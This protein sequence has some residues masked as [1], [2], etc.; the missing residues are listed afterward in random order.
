M[1]GVTMQA[2]NVV[3]NEKQMSYNIHWKECMDK[4]HIFFMYIFVMDVNSMVGGQGWMWMNVDE[5]HPPWLLNIIAQMK[6]Q[7]KEKDIRM[8]IGFKPYNYT[9]NDHISRSRDLFFFFTSK[10]C[11][12]FNLVCIQFTFAVHALHCLLWFFGLLLLN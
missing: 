9:L 12:N 1:H 7:T 10:G 11:V 8:N 4:T 6:N 2:F 3:R 5:F